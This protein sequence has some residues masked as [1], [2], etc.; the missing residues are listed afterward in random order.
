MAVSASRDHFMLHGRGLRPHQL[1]VGA[2]TES[3]TLDIY[4]S[5]RESMHAMDEMFIS[6]FL[7]DPL[8][9]LPV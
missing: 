6:M 4:P 5:T 3:A 9:L 2:A 1:G 8:L 7:A